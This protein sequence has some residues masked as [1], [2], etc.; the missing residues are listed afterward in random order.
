ML[1]CARVLGRE[2]SY[3]SPPMPHRKRYL[4]VCTNRR[5][6]G[7]PK[8]SCAQKGAEPVIKNPDGTKT[9]VSRNARDLIFHI[10]TTMRNSMLLSVNH[11][12]I[13]CVTGIF[14]KSR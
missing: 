6:E 10:A 2:P 11:R 7:N 12:R 4:F 8:G 5:E 3:A 9:L 1:S 14:A 13:R